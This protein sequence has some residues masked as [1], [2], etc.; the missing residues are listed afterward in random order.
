MKHC[1][2]DWVDRYRKKRTFLT[3]DDNSDCLQGVSNVDYED[4][5]GCTIPL[6]PRE[7]TESMTFIQW[8]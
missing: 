5:A 6:L 2:C 4:T 1:I 8:A 3:M 7:E